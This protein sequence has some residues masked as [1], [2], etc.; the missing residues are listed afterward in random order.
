MIRSRAQS[1]RTKVTN[2][3]APGACYSQI[4]LDPLPPGAP[5]AKG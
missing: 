1:R 5:C 3:R 2:K 4:A